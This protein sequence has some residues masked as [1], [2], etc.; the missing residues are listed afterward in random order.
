M[1]QSRTHR[2]F[3]DEPFTVVSDTRGAVCIVRNERYTP[4]L[5]HADD[6]RAQLLV[7][8]TILENLPGVS[9]DTAEMN[10]VLELTGGKG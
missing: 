2:G 7:A 4:L 10:R 6:L 8:V 1:F 9:V 5:T 3:Y